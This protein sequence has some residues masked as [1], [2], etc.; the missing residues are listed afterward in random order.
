MVGSPHLTLTVDNSFVLSNESPISL[1]AG[2]INV[3]RWQTP[4]HLGRHRPALVLLAGEQ[5]STPAIR[6]DSETILYVEFGQ[7]LPQISSDGATLIV[8]AVAGDVVHHLA[9]VTLANELS[10]TVRSLRLSLG[11]LPSDLVMIAIEVG[12]GAQGDPS[13]DWVSVISLVVGASHELDLL[14]ARAFKAIRTANEI[15]H[16]ASVYDHAIY[17]ERDKRAKGEDE[18]APVTE[19][20]AIL[21]LPDPSAPLPGEH[22]F[23]YGQR[24]LSQSLR[25]QPPDFAARLRAKATNRPL[26]VASLCAG[27]AQIEASIFRAAQVPVDLTLVDISDKLLDKAKSYMPEG[28]ETRVLVQDVNQLDLEP[29]S[30]DIVACVSGIHH[31]VELERIWLQIRRGLGLDGELWLIGEQIGANG[32]R[33]AETDYLAGNKTFRA[34]PEPYR[35]NAYTGQVDDNL[36]NRDCSEATFE[37]IRSQ[38]IEQTLGHFFLPAHVYKRNCFLW[39]LLNQTY[40]ENYDLTRPEDVERV[41]GLVRTELTHFANG[42]TPTELHG[43]YVPL[44]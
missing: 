7:G 14:K 32:N 26:R 1:L 30:Y 2:P 11:H 39:M 10:P 28:V 22:V 16:F 31:A 19:S 23:A 8:T 37:G 34:L 44:G 40:S 38:D 43:V 36:P 27:T 3:Q 4:V 41:K 24:L 25:M 18:P 29:N 13:A 17:A 20:P 35:R 15:A 5:A 42:G 9:T 12:P 33:L 21:S 6:I